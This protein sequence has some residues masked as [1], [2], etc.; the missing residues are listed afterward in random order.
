MHMNELRP[1]DNCGDNS[2]L[3]QGLAAFE[4]ADFEQAIELLL[5]I[6][7]RA[8]G[9]HEAWWLLVEAYCGEGTTESPL[10]PFELENSSEALIGRAMATQ[11]LGLRCIQADS[12]K[13]K[14]YLESAVK[15]FR[16]LAD[17]GESRAMAALGMCYRG[18]MGLPR[19]L[20]SAIRWSTLAFENGAYGDANNLCLIYDEEME[21]TPENR[22]RARYWYWKTKQHNCQCIRI[23][24]FEQLGPPEDETGG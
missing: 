15:S 4:R 23:R 2:V 6:S 21:Q 8:Q 3:L 1:P 19:D 9:N 20:A 17:N 5:P 7:S 10:R 16:M 13:A 24:E 14:A 18:G 12:A 22:Q 11:M